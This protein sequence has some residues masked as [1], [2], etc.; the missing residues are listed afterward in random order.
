LTKGRRE[1]KDHCYICAGNE[2]RMPEAI[3]GSQ[4]NTLLMNLSSLDGVVSH[5]YL[6]FRLKLTLW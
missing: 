5:E 6:G 3:V 4:Y 2:M 1:E